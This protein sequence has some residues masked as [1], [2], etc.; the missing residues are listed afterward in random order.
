MAGPDI[1]AQEWN[2]TKAST[3][4]SIYLLHQMDEGAQIPII[5]DENYQFIEPLLERMHSKNYIRIEDDS[6]RLSEHGEEVLQR[7]DNRY[8]EYLRF[9]DI[10]SAV[11]PN[12][13]EFAFAKYF[14]FESDDAWSQYLN[15]ERWEDLRIAVARLKKLDA[16]EIVFMSF[17]NENIFG[18]D[19]NGWQFDL[20]LGSVWDEIRDICRN[21]VTSEDLGGEEKLLELT[22]QGSKLM[23]ELLEHEKKLREWQ[24]EQD[25]ND[26]NS[27]G[28]NGQDD[29]YEIVEI[30]E[31]YAY[32]DPYYVSPFWILPL[33]F[34]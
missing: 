4:A 11:D 27:D 24:L 10:F 20:I 23:I 13:G 22:R 17:L 2:E 33:F 29:D 21:A 16:H 34:F 7:F 25:K 26:E 6:Y 19:E 14:D 5:P 32:Q 15:D 8:R 28:V 1:E 30:E 18:S 9:Y 12:S 3:F 31:Y